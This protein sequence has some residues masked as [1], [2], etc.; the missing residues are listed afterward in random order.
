MTAT[1]DSGTRRRTVPIG[2]AVGILVGCTAWALAFGALVVANGRWQLVVECVLPVVLGSFAVGLFVLACFQW[3]LALPPDRAGAGLLVPGAVVC[4]MGL[5]LVLADGYVTPVLE[6]DS[7][8]ADFVRST[9]GVVA[10]P[11]PLALAA[12]AA[13]GSM[14]AIALR[15][16]ASAN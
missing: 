4:A 8:L 14:L 10:L 9:G 3:K 2:A 6:A 5:L 16:I 15:R 1:E 11:I 7:R 13:G 12:L